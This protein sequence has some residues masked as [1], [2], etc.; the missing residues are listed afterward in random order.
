MLIAPSAIVQTAAGLQQQLIAME[1]E[2]RREVADLVASVEALRSAVSEQREESNRA[3]A[4]E[5][6]AAREAVAALQTRLA[7][8]S[9]A[10]GCWVGS[11]SLRQLA[12]RQGHCRMARAFWRGGVQ[13]QNACCG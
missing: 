13:R 11:L 2:H 8:A 4:S 6:R 7:A 3:L 5:R 12:A 10:A 9:G 1:A